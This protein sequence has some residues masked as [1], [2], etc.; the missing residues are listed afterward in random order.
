MQIRY[1]V[2]TMIFW[3][4][5]NHLSLEQECQ[6]L[7]SQGFGVELWPNMKG[8]ND[9][10]YER[11]NWPRL[12]AAT[13]GMLV[14]MRSRDNGPTLEQWNEQIECA[15][16][17]GANIVADLQ[18]MRIPN[19]PDVDGCDFAADV[20]KLAEDNDVKL[21]L[22]TGSLAAL[23][24]VG[25]RFE[26]IRYCL[27]TG[28]INLDPKF[29]FREYVD[30]LGERVVHLHLT[31]NYGRID[32]HEP[33]GLRGGISRQNWQYLLNALSK[34]DNDVVGSLEMFPCMPAVML[35]QAS[36]FLFDE[37]KW[38]NRPQKKPDYAGVSYNPT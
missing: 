38:P 18:N 26:S 20:I 27:D 28:Y 22:E 19:S 25:K 17:L 16:L 3:W 1:A 14:A 13:E 4:R 33:P 5:E 21:C 36:E 10:R 23:K 35:R 37:L 9:C 31:D 29:S 8:Q 12:A 30:D 34:Y 15:K 24:Q 32:D 2:S 6:F 11:R 7:R